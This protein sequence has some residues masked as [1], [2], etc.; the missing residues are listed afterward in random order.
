MDGKLYLI[1]R[2]LCEDALACNMLDMILLQASLKI[3][4]QHVHF[5]QDAVIAA[6]DGSTFQKKLRDLMGA[7]VTISVQKEDVDARGQFPLVE[8]I[9]ILTYGDA[10]D[11]IF[12][13]QK[14]CSNI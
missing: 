2:S 13:S 1:G 8:G 6:R 9:K 5:L 3:T 14:L 10:V 4:G 7:G 12:H 11:L